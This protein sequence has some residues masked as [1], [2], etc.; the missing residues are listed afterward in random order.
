MSISG[1]F[2]DVVLLIIGWQMGSAYL[3]G[4]YSLESI[5]S[6]VS[7]AIAA[8]LVAVLVYMYWRRYKMEKG[9]EA[10]GGEI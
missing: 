3:Q 4:A 6:I 2:S 10:K 5:T 1:V 9:R 7:K 8:I